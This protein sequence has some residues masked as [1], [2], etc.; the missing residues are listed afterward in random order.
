MCILFWLFMCLLRVYEAFSRA[1]TLLVWILHVSKGST[2][3]ALQIKTDP[4][5]HGK[6][7]MSVLHRENRDPGASKCFFIYVP[8]SDWNQCD[9]NI[10]VTR[11]S[12]MSVQGLAWNGTAQCGGGEGAD[13]VGMQGGLA[14]EAASLS[15]QGFLSI[16][17]HHYAFPV[18]S[19]LSFGVSF[20]R[21]F[22]FFP[23][24]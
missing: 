2:L 17:H 10:Q 24:F 5:E 23:Y 13:L 9:P 8:R 19:G 11:A 3:K 14:C 7:E 4:M 6:R 20:F 12:E 22:F 18:A 16:M 15:P 21:G 1:A